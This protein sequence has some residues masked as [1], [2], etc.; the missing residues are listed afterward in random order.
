MNFLWEEIFPGEPINSGANHEENEV[1]FTLKWVQRS[2]K[3]K[4]SFSFSKECSFLS[5]DKLA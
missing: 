3:E 1:Y 5:I 4:K 2:K